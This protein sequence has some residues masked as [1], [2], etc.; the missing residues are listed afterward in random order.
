MFYCKI[1]KP[2]FDFFFSLLGL[3]ILSPVFIVIILLLLIINNDSPFFVHMRP[4]RGERVFGLIKFKTMSDIKD[5]KDT[6]IRGYDRITPIG[7]FLRTTSLDE[8]PQL[9]NVLKGDMSVIG[10]RPLKVDYLPLYNNFQKR[11][12]DVKPGIT[13]WAQVNGR[14]TITW[15]EKFEFD[16]WYV[17]NLCLKTDLKIF[18]MTVLR[19]LN[20][21]GIN[22]GDGFTMDKFTGSN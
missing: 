2:V 18:W 7:H 12:H 9:I 1:F 20:R 13:G 3:I 21:E 17:E 4:G 8:I 16:I 22:S 5:E 15:D 10:P 19:T 6:T 14:N 11:R